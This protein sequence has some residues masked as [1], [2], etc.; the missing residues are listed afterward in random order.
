MP[1]FVFVG[2]QISIEKFEPERESNLGPTDLYSDLAI[3][4]KERERE[5]E[6]ETARERTRESERA[7]ERKRSRIEL[8]IEPG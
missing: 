3:Q 7:R 6:R 4:E 5:R 1:I 8:S 2:F